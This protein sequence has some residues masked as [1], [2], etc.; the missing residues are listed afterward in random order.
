VLPCFVPARLQSNSCAPSLVCVSIVATLALSC[1]LLSTTIT[2]LCASLVAAHTTPTLTH[3]FAHFPAFTATLQKHDKHGI[4]PI[5]A[6]IWEGHTAV[7]Q[8][9]LEAV[10]ACRLV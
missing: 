7:V 2:L 4:T 1:C 9:L 5:L 8:Y 10:S 3:P 6:A